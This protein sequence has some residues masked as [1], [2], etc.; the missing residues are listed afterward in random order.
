MLKQDLFQ[1][2]IFGKICKNISTRINDPKNSNY[3]KYVGLK[4]LDTL[5]PKILR[6]GS[7]QNVKSSMTLFAKKQ[8]L[9]G[10][11]NW[12]LRRVAVASFD[13]ICSADIYVLEAKGSQIL[14]DFLPIFMHS[15]QFFEETMKYSS[16]SMST[17]VKWSDLEKIQFAMPF[18]PEQKKIIKIISVID[19]SITK[20]QNL[21]DKLKIY[22]ESKANDL[23]TRGIGHTKFKKVKWLFGKEIEI[24]EEWKVKRFDEIFEF[25]ATATNSRSDLDNSGD[26]QYIHYGDI[27]TKWNLVLDCDVEII[28]YIAKTKVEKI[29]LLTEGDLIIADASED[30]EGSGASVLLKNAQNKKIVSGLHTMALRDNQE[31]T[32]IDFRSYLISIQFVKNQIVAYVTG[33]SV[34]GLS[35]KNL[36]KVKI[37]LPLLKEQQKIASILT[38]LDEQYKQLENHLS[39]L[40]TMRKSMINEKLTPPILRKKIVQ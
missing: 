22:K 5:E 28:P 19:E 31:N 30:H 40:K 16:G 15:N 11:R 37:P 10:R 9:F 13:G 7:T 12:Y 35:K 39:L 6:F 20:T 14:P 23:L 18:I 1:D 29:P 25:L 38:Q 8:I 21:L 36:K 4:H 32:S 27:H 2:I 17:R 26:I 34:Y 33:I 3:E 24:P